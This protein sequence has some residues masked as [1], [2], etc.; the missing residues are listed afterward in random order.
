MHFSIITFLNGEKVNI[1]MAKTLLD[2]KRWL[3]ETS[4]TEPL[5]LSKHNQP[6]SVKQTLKSLIKSRRIAEGKD[7]LQVDF[8]V[9]KTKCELTPEE[10]KKQR[11]R[12]EQNRRAAMRCRERKKEELKHL[13]KEENSLRMRREKLMEKVEILLE[14]KEKLLHTIRSTGNVPFS[15]SCPNSEGDCI[16]CLSNS[17][18]NLQS[19]SSSSSR[20]TRKPIISVADSCDSETDS[21]NDDESDDEDGDDESD[22]LVIDTKGQNEDTEVL[23]LSFSKERHDVQMEVTDSDSQPSSSQNYSSFEYNEPVAPIS[24]FPAAGKSSGQYNPQDYIKQEETEM[25]ESDYVMSSQESTM[26]FYSSQDSIDGS[27]I[28]HGGRNDDVSC[29]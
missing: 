9:E 7:E 2:G 12:K 14:E 19:E 10:K 28:K 21:C 6:T 23:D 5:N 8:H 24:T 3:K 22:R 16:H 26:S 20:S 11:E 29:D 25:E 27:F 17:D 15:C 18:S 13:Q 4:G 1:K